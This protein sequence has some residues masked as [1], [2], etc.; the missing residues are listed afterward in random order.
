MKKSKILVLEDEKQYARYI[1][2]ELIHEGYEVV[3]SYNG[4]EGIETAKNNEIDLLLL[5]INLP[6]MS[7]MEVC[8]RIRQFSSVPIIMVTSRDETIDKVMGLDLGANDYVTKPFVIDEFLARIRAAI[9]KSDI[10][11]KESKKLKINDL[12][13]DT[14]KRKVTRGNQSI[15]LTKR[16]YDLLEYLAI[17]N[18]I[19]LTRDRIIE[20]VWGYDYEGDI[21]VV[22]VYIKY[23]RSKVDESFE[24][25][26][27]HTIRGVGYM[28]ME[29]EKG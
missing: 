17:N 18:G 23:L 13:V 16:E 9:R 27:I 21:N 12:I 25:K 24:T 7:G 8:K 29:E 3:I 5:D 6:G 1:E 19:V 14:L 4:I 10:I 26:L 15:D 11:K 2:L 20:N 22:D 28:I